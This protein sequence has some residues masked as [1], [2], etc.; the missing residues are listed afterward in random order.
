LPELLFGLRPGIGVCHRRTLCKLSLWP[1]EGECYLHRVIAS[2][3]D[4]GRS[5][6][7]V[8]G[9]IAMARQARAKND[10]KAKGLG[11]RPLGGDGPAAEL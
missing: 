11:M 9:G 6:L 5:N 2:P 8:E 10:K 7:V 1:G 4:E 3:S